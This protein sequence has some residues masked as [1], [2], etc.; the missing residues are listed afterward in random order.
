MS[1]KDFDS[2]NKNGG[3]KNDGHK[4]RMSLVPQVALMEVAKIMTYGEY[5]YDA[6]NWMNG[7]NWTFLTDAIDRHKIAFLCGEDI[8]PESGFHHMGHVA[9]SS[10][11][12][13]ENCYLHP[14]RDDRWKGWQTEPGKIALK[15]A[16]EPFKKSEY[17]INVLEKKTKG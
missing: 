12:A 1:L 4:P 2:K 9:A 13:L 11:M 3:I 7:F 8:D 6:Y 15:M 5:K 10:L 17:L 16:L 14:E